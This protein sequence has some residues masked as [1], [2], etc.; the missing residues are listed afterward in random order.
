[1][2]VCND[3]GFK[4]KLKAWT[5]NNVLCWSNSNLTTTSFKLCREKLFCIHFWSKQSWLFKGN[6]VTKWKWAITT[7]STSGISQTGEINQSQADKTTH[8]T[9]YQNIISKSSNFHL[10]ELSY[11]TFPFI[12]LYPHWL[13][14]ISTT[15]SQADIDYTITCKFYLWMVTFAVYCVSLILLRHCV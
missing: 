15:S 1:M 4:G 14:F 6:H 12:W 8:F 2:T 13:C 10:C 5:C 3:D 11:E 7:T 9:L